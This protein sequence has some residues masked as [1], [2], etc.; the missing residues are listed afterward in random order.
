MAWRQPSR[1]TVLCTKARRTTPRN[2][3]LCTGQSTVPPRK[4]GECT[5][6]AP[7]L[8]RKSALCTNRRACPPRKARACTSRTRTSRL[9]L[10]QRAASLGTVCGK[11]YNGRVLSARERKADPCR[12]TAAGF[13][14]HGRRHFSS[15]YQ[16]AFSR[17]LNRPP[18]PHAAH[19]FA[20]AKL[21]KS[22]YLDAFRLPAPIWLINTH[23]STLSTRS[24][25][26][27]RLKPQAVVA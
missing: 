8:L 12:G 3:A 18:N 13:S 6:P 15:Q 16:G 4:A 1:K 14:R 23:I 21:R 7:L 9:P 25:V 27:C 22:Y 20:N 2:E 19:T 5:R 17:P 26:F 24:S 11:W 10:V